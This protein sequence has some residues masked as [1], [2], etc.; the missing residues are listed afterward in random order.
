M[1][2]LA[3]RCEIRR[4]GKR[5]VAIHLGEV[6]PVDGLLLSDTALLDESALTGEAMPVS[7]QRG[8][9][10]SSG[11]V[12]AGEALEMRA[13]ADA[14]SSTYAGIVRLAEQ[15]QEAKAPFTRLADRYALLFIPLTLLLA[16]AAWW[17]SGDAVRALAVLVVATPCP[18]ILAVPIALVS[19]TSQAARRGILVKS[20][21]ALELLAQAWF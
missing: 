11:V 21:G 17:W 2:V 6:L 13:L 4:E 9:R 7:R 5:P 1:E 15:A 12:N 16:G 20:G 3:Q 14:A 8:E 19:A 18:L 10:L